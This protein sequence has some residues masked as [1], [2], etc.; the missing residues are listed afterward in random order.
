MARRPANIDVAYVRE[1]LANGRTQKDIAAELHVHPSVISTH[2]AKAGARD[3]TP[4]A[5][6]PVTPAFQPLPE[7]YVTVIQPMRPYTEEE[8]AALNTS[9]DLYG[10][11]G[12][13]VRDQ[14]G[15][16]LDGNH[17]DRLATAKGLDVPYTV[18][19]VKDDLH[20][21]D[22][23]FTLNT[24]RREYTPAERE[25]IGL[26]LRAQG[27][28][29]RRIGMALGVSQVQAMHDVKTAEAAV[30]VNHLT[31][32]PPIAPDE[33]THESATVNHLTV[34]LP[35]QITGRDGR[36]QP[37]K[38]SVPSTIKISAQDRHLAKII[39]LIQLHAP[40]WKDQHWS[41]FLDTVQHVR[42]TVRV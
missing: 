40:T 1:A 28:S 31:V 35:A 30:T 25:Q 34:T 9:F 7:G 16:I 12:S 41:K 39:E 15:R 27:Y 18:T 8:E 21:K 22:V 36:R 2:L 17:R 37:A 20:A 29:Y 32:E 38:R 19:T 10:F 3:P 24:V 11:L 14:Y 4:A 13:I 26:T 42:P 5:T 33:P 6:R 23:A